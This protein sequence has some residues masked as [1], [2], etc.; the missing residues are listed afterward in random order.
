MYGEHVKDIIS[1]AR[2]KLYC[3]K[4]HWLHPA[5]QNFYDKKLFCS[6][7]NSTDIY[8]II[9]VADTLLGLINPSSSL[10]VYLSL[11]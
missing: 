4:P 5:K 3:D 2:L 6:N 1:F 10:H 7:C 8:G 11:L 9:A